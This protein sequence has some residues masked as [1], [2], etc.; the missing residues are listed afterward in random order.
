MV[1]HEAILAYTGLDGTPWHN[2]LSR[3][4]GQE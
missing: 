1:Y 4:L 2:E 3:F